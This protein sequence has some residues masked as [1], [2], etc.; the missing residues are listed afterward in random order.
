MTMSPTPLYDDNLKLRHSFCR[1]LNNFTILRMAEA[2][3][4]SSSI[5]ALLASPANPQIKSPL[6]AVIPPEIRREI[7]SFV[8]ADFTDPD[9]KAK[10]DQL[11]YYSKPY[12]SAPRKSDTTLLRACRLI[13]QETWFIPFSLREIEIWLTG[14]ER[15]PPGYLRYWSNMLRQ[16]TARGIP[17][18]ENPE[19]PAE[20]QY[21]PN[22]QEIRSEQQHDYAEEHG[23]EDDEEV[24]FAIF[25]EVYLNDEYYA[26]SPK[27]CFR[28]PL[29]M[30]LAT[31]K[32]QQGRSTELASV[33][34]F[35]Q[36]VVLEEGF[37]S[38]SLAIPEFN[39]RK[40]TLTIRHQDWWWWE[41]NHPLRFE[42]SQILPGTETTMSQT[43]REFC[44][45]LESLEAYKEQ[46]DLIASM[47]R[48]RWFFKRKDGI[49]LLAEVSGKNDTKSR[50]IGP[51]TFDGRRWKQH[52]AE[53]GKLHYYNRTITFRT[54]VAI[55]KAGGKVSDEAKENG[56]ESIYDPKRLNLR[57]ERNIR[58]NGWQEADQGRLF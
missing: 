15:A 41:N 36:M 20:F 32:E 44:V 5:A 28:F 19:Y 11:T 47:M 2:P 58:D 31:I 45:E 56:K 8:L 43:V 40:V 50:W 24:G 10:Y 29:Q 18:L 52:E 23:S 34:F 27:E 55:E 22:E 53:D 1:N 35:A 49:P 17:Q 6:L 13:F 16:L 37:L 21:S 46:I 48:E 42:G 9:A 30:L 57:L 54:E 25:D 14:S 38:T 7:W 39:P 4:I 3:S 33:R 12:C 51:S 26:Y